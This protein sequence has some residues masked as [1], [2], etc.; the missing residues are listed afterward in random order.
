MLPLVGDLDDTLSIHILLI[1]NPSTIERKSSSKESENK[2][3]TAMEIE[4]TTESSVE[5][6]KNRFALELEFG[7]FGMLLAWWTL[8]S[9]NP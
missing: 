2:M 4:T 1:P 6:P 3:A 8:V 7:R 9:G 5:L